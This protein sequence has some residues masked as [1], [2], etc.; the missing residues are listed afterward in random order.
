[1]EL[2]LQV[3]L[4]LVGVAIAVRGSMRCA[5]SVLRAPLIWVGISFMVLAT[6]EAWLQFGEFSA[7]SRRCV[8]LAAA[9]I[10]FCPGMAVL[11]AK[12]PQ[13]HGWHFVVFTMWII[14]ALPAAEML[15]STRG[16]SMRVGNLRS[17]FM[18]GAILLSVA[19]YLPTR[20]A[21]PCLLA[22]TGQLIL[23]SPQLPEFLQLRL[24][25]AAGSLQPWG[26]STCVTLALVALVL[27]ATIAARSVEHPSPAPVWDRRWLRFR[28][29]FGAFWAVRLL[30]RV[31]QL[32]KERNWQ[33][34]LTWTGFRSVENIPPPPVVAEQNPV[35][36]PPTSMSASPPFAE[37][38]AWETIEQTLENVLRRF[39][40]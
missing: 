5:H 36:G 6:A 39:D 37:A 14:L 2:A 27:A 40:C 15:I 13:Q 20:F 12:R 26:E 23:L 10:T 33:F 8:R 9:C 22:A 19:N 3:G 32:T 16:E 25:L 29:R 7:D 28:D 30:Q 4:A 38:A 18:V 34:V 21:I 11:G 31:N 1:M 17:W 35:D 24:W